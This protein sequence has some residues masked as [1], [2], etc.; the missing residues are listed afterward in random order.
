MLGHRVTAVAS[1]EDGLQAFRPGQFDA[2]VTDLQLPGMSGLELAEA[3]RRAQPALLVV[4]ASG[5]GPA[6]A[7]QGG[8]AFLHLPKPYRVD[9][10][11]AILREAGATAAV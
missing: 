8:H 5:M 3:L 10:L 11:E 9:Q 2:L 4:I 7:P 1:A 6:A